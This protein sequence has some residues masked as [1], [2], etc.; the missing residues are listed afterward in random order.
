MRWHRTRH[1]WWFSKDTQSQVTVVDTPT[2]ET[3]LRRFGVDRRRVNNADSVISMIRRVH[4]VVL[5][6]FTARVN[7][8]LVRKQAVSSAANL[9][10]SFHLSF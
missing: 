4:K 3:H 6:M 1:T 2:Q 5:Q 8:H 7:S 9:M 10:L